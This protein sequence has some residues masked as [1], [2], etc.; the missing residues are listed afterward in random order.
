MKVI[1]RPIEMIAHCPLSGIPRP[2]RFRT[3]D[4]N[5]ESLVIKI[6][7]V[8]EYREEKFAGN[9]MY[10]YRCQALINGEQKLMELK[11]E[12]GTCLWYLFKI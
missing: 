10:I 5:K 12:I 9:K 6:N 4:K 2:I 1:A 3:E 7:Q 8:Q 11:Y